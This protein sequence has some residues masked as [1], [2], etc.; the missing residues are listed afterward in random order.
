M[1]LLSFVLLILLNQTLLFEVTDDFVLNEELF[2]NDELFEVS[3]IDS[4]DVLLLAHES[5]NFN[6]FN[7]SLATFSSN[8]SFSDSL[9]I[10][11]SK[12]SV[13]ASLSTCSDC[14]EQILESCTVANTDVC[15]FDL[16]VSLQE[17]VSLGEAIRFTPSIVPSQESFVIT[18]T[19]S[20]I[21]GDV[22][23]G[24][25]TTNNLNPKQFTPRS[26][27]GFFDVIVLEV[28]ASND[29]SEKTQTKYVVVVNQDHEEELIEGEL[30][31]EKTIC[32]VE[33]SVLV[34]DI[35]F[36]GETIRFTPT[37][38]VAQN[39]FSLSYWFEDLQGLV[40]RDKQKT[41]N[42]NPKQFTP[43]QRLLNDYA[44]VFLLFLEFE[45]ECVL[46]SI[47]KTV[48]VIN[49]LAQT[50]ELEEGLTV[51]EEIIS[52]PLELFV[53]DELFENIPVI[54]QI[55]NNGL[56]TQEFFVST[57]VYRH[58]VNFS[59]R[60]PELF[61]VPAQTSLNISYDFTLEPGEYSLKAQLWPPNRRT[62]IEERTTIIVQE[63]VNIESLA[64]NITNNSLQE[65]AA[66]VLPP[67]I[68]S[69]AITASVVA[70]ENNL[71]E[72]LDIGLLVAVLIAAI[73]WFVARFMSRQNDASEEKIL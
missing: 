48:V 70:Q 55:T 31:E 40:V 6:S 17:K 46:N 61:V 43:P 38:S 58:S 36:A 4:S 25:L 68:E 23:R 24:P 9:I 32:D 28:T 19:W 14:L 5:S 37:L 21:M 54:T 52:S 30:I 20:N 63:S 59:D 35:L 12:N 67:R 33:L 26:I 7:C 53:P 13:N 42:L 18:Y 56:L 11:N 69:Q 66:I 57:Y 22:L 34:D 39:N 45:N 16:S 41:N 65:E 71:R 3:L 8:K 47:N 10:N 44:N 72:Y 73:L 51:T 60:T 29:C 15:D 50:K 2:L 62:A 64:K 27:D 49:E 1:E